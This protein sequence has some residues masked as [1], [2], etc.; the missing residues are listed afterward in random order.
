LPQAARVTYDA[1]QRR[2]ILALPAAHVAATGEIQ[3]Y[4]PSAAGMDR[5]LSLRL[6]AQGQ[7]TLDAAALGEGLWRVRVMWRVGDEEFACD[8]KVVI[9][10][11]TPA[12]SSRTLPPS[13]FLN[14]KP[15]AQSKP[16]ARNSKPANA[17]LFESS[18]PLVAADVR[19]LHSSRVSAPF[20]ER[21]SLLTSAAT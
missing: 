6:D 19:R 9:G 11:A 7:Q 12:P 21:E 3:L 1:V 14:A 17:G 2:L 4:R 13:Q 8:E 5:R 18:D 10:D 15:E 20:A 16:E